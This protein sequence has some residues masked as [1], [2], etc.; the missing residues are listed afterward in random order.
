MASAGGFPASFYGEPGVLGLLANGISAFL[1]LLQNFNGA[2]T[3][4]P[5]YGVENILAGIH[6]ILIG[7]VCQLLAGLLSF[8]KYDHL[9]GTSFIG[10]AA[11]WGSYGATRIFLGASEPPINNTSGQIVLNLTLGPELAL[12]LISRSAIAGLIPYIGLSFIL[13]FCS[14]TVNYIMP[15]VFGAITATLIFEAVGLVGG[16]ALV[17]SG[18]LELFILL[19]AIY[20]STALLIK[21]IAQRYVLKGFGSPLFNVLLLGTANANTSQ[22]L[23]Q[24]KKKNTKYAE[25]MALGFFCDTISPFI[26]AFFC[27]RYLGSFAVGAAWVSIIS[28]AQLLSSYYA[29]LRHDCYYTTKFGLHS[30][31]WL[32][33][34][35]EEYVLSFE[36]NRVLTDGT[37]E[38][39]VGNWFFVAIAIVLCVVSLNMDTLEVVHNI[40]FFLLTISTISQI[41]LNG[42]YIFFGVTC[43]L[44]TA[45]SLYG[46][47]ARLIN[48]IAEKLLIP[49]GPQPISTERLQKG[50]TI[51]KKGK[52]REQLQSALRD[53]SA[54]LPDA[55]FYITNGL[56]ALSAIHR[57][58]TNQFF[59][60][61][62][63]P[64]VLISGAIMQ[65]YVS[66][67]QVRGGQRFG[68]VIPSFY[69]ATWATW[70][71]YRFAGHLLGISTTSASG[72][73]A[74]AIAFLVANAFIILIA[75]YRN[76]VLLS[77]TTMMEVL[78]V[79]FLLSTLDRLPYQLEIAIL[80]I[81]S[82]IC[83][84]GA[85]AS[86]VNCIFSKHLV[87]LG[88]PL[89]R[90]TK[91]KE[92]APPPPCLVVDSRLTSGLITIARLLDQGSV[93]G[94]PTDT[95]Y[96]LAASCKN[97]KAIEK[98]YN[99]KVIIVL[100]KSIN[101]CILIVLCFNN[102]WL[103]RVSW[104]H[105]PSISFHC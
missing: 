59:L 88:P 103:T 6:L 97:P 27:F 24:E 78:L 60:H 19:F 82:I 50:L 101:I 35:W 25:P 22:S 89:L 17:V 29:Y 42:Y 13:A 33:K 18:V 56:A 85:M 5:A 53:P 41:P 87:P 73:T 105:Y 99:I 81:F 84:Y 100:E 36:M 48:T 32:V 95:V 96:A 58:Q 68:S 43:S 102:N 1:V 11:L 104:K 67:L 34:A 52:D 70:T 21:G 7:G 47:F 4:I 40:F 74:G 12:P 15:F 54:H 26:F 57:S 83:V 51:L 79:C 90:N 76:L 98:I 55:L 8:R 45:I 9:S 44:F 86:L 94:I 65:V 14:A 23:G 37:R 39:M 80:A 71:W 93:C 69:A 49:V 46:T 92:V 20:G 3:G 61:L 62:T 64:W 91:K 66:R 28:A 30:A 75:A 31:Y 16:W 72:F 77:L 2:R 38:A 63:V 10:Y